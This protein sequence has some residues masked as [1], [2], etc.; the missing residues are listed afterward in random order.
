M[1]LKKTPEIQ[2]LSARQNN[3]M[4]I[5]LVPKS[6]IESFKVDYICD[7]GEEIVID[8]ILHV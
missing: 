6:F 5:T 1:N 3:G 8:G 4:P 2:R 7:V